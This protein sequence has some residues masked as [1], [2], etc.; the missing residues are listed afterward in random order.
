MLV[1]VIAVVFFIGDGFVFV[2]AFDSCS[3]FFGRG[4]AIGFVRGA[5]IGCF[6]GRGAAIGCCFCGRGAGIGCCTDTAGSSDRA[7]TAGSAGRA[8]FFDWV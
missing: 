6:C 5:A 7:D 8:G 3:G 1:L 2:Y 4:A